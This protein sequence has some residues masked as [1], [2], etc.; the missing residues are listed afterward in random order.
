MEHLKL[1]DFIGCTLY[2]TLSK[3]RFIQG[4]LVAVDSQA[5]LL[6]DY[7][8]ER[9]ITKDITNAKYN[10]RLMGLVSVPSDTIMSIKIT[11]TKV[12][13]LVTLKNEML[14]SIV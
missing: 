14:S 13:K 1:G 8:W 10:D 9:T 2:I 5:N 4:T 6:L 11:K 12:N 3:E 7:V